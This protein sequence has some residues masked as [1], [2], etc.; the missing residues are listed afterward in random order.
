[1]HGVEL[2]KSGNG[3]RWSWQGLCWIRLG[4]L[5]G[6]LALALASPSAAAR[7]VF[8]RIRVDGVINPIK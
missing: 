1:M 2:G 5:L 6:V 7:D 4:S 3:P 8:L